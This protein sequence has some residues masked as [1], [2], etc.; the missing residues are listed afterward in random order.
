M[1]FALLDS[2]RHKGPQCR[3][4]APELDKLYAKYGGE[5]LAIVGISVNEDRQIVEKFL[6]RASASV[7]D[8]LDQ[9]ERDAAPVSRWGVPHI[10]GDCFRRHV[11]FR[12]GR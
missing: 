7:P 11:G 4:D 10:P 12:R 5:D 6:K 1:S 2:H 3:A 8:R 9:R